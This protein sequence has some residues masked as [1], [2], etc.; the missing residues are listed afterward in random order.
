MDFERYNK[1]L[2]YPRKPARPKCCGNRYNKGDKFCCKC[3]K[4]INPNY[5]ELTAKYNEEMRKYREETRRIEELFHKDIAKEFGLTGHSKEQIL[6]N[7]A[8]DRASNFEE[9]YDN[10][11]E[12]S[13]LLT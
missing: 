4:P 12:M 2:E 13:E 11:E 8:W 5:D 3:G 9:A 7:L 10:Y 6:Y 1:K